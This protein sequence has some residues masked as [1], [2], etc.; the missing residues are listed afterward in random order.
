MTLVKKAPVAFLLSLFACGCFG[1]PVVV[2]RP[3]P[4]VGLERGFQDA[5]REI[6]RLKPEACI[7]KGMWANDSN[8]VRS[9]EAGPARLIARCADGSSWQFRYAATP[10]P[11][12]ER[13]HRH[14]AGFWLAAVDASRWREFYS[15]EPVERQGRFHV[16]LL[17][18]PED[19]A[20]FADAWVVLA[21]GVGNDYIAEDRF[22]AVV[23]AYRAGTGPRTLSDRADRLRIEAEFAIKQSRFGDALAAY[24]KALTLDPWWPAG[25][26]NRALIL[27]EVEE[28]AAAAGEM[29]RFLALEPAAENAGAAKRKII[30]WSSLAR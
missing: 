15:D 1:P 17:G 5:A 26:Y 30:E 22:A 18:G 6:E 20:R 28:Y 8:T 4:S 27:A 7:L 9:I 12:V 3:D 14:G 19:D 2:Y 11:A 25:H 21:R 29:E 23:D 13:D 10:L 16:Y 24:R